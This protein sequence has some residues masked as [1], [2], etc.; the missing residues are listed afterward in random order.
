[1]KIRVNK[2][3]RDNNIDFDNITSYKFKSNDET[4]SEFRFRLC[5]NKKEYNLT[6]Q[7]IADIIY[8]EFNIKK[9][10]DAYRKYWK[11]FCENSSSEQNDHNDSLSNLSPFNQKSS[12]I[13][14][15]QKER[16]KLQATKI[17]LNRHLR[18]SSRFE[19]LY[20]NIRDEI[21]ALSVP[22]LCV[23]KNTGNKENDKYVLAISDIHYGAQYTLKDHTYSR[24][25]CRKRFEQL[26]SKL[27]NVIQEK[28]INK[29]TVINLG[30]SVQG[31]IHLNDAVMNEIPVVQAVVEISCILADFLNK[32]SAHCKVEYY[33]VPSANHSQ[34]RPLN[35]KPNELATEDFEYIIINYIKDSLR[36]NK[37]VYVYNRLD[38]D[39]VSFN[40]FD[41][42]FVAIHGHQ[43]KKI[44]D[45]LKDI[46]F[47]HNCKYDYL[48]MGH[49][50]SEREIVQG[51]NNHKNRKIFIVPSF[52][53][54]NIYSNKIMKSSKSEVKLYRFNETYGH[55]ETSGMILD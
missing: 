19:L 11:N 36:N 46:S 22:E 16:Y 39:Y 25:Q 26:L 54:I 24:V 2:N 7:E 50:H 1:M 9:S 6:W 5:S 30:D 28:K 40:L 18:Q 29:I 49:F 3:N 23:T 32:L 38:S 27:T 45:A 41:S 44:E 42:K 13:Y 17:E 15:I 20:E 35:S 55:V 48:F 43:I 34:I 52:V 14:N 33:H 37:R 31:M 4:F 51:I 10:E 8:K 21:K 12:D 47:H 53:G